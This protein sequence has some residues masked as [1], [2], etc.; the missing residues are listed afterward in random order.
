MGMDLTNMETNE[1]WPVV[2]RHSDLMVRRDRLHGNLVAMWAIVRDPGLTHH[3][4]GDAL[5]QVSRLV[6][7]IFELWKAEEEFY[8]FERRTGSERTLELRERLKELDQADC[9]HG[10]VKRTCGWC[11]AVDLEAQLIDL[12]AQSQRG[13]PRP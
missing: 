8:S 7:W 9:P 11:Y 4:R 10:Q 12:K 1:V 2:P 5:D 13:E 6:E 3:A